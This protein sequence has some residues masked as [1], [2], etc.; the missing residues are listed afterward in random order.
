MAW[1]KDYPDI[2]GVASTGLTF[3]ADTVSGDAVV[4]LSGSATVDKAAGSWN[5]IDTVTGQRKLVFDD[6]TGSCG[7]VCDWD[8]VTFDG[9]NATTANLSAA[10]VFGVGKWSFD[11]VG[12]ED[13]AGTALVNLG[14]RFGAAS[15]I[16]LRITDAASSLTTWSLAGVS[17]SQSFEDT[18]FKL[19]L[20][21]A[22]GAAATVELGQAIGSGTFKDYG[23]TV[24]DNTLKFASLA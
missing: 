5:G 14:D 17:A 22:T 1:T 2:D 8:L 3:G 7:A 4:T 6:Y 10:T 18:S 9:E 13:N 24:V 12:R 20:G 23:F 21:D 11:V 15:E 16:A 19:Y